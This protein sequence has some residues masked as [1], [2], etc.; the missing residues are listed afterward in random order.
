MT[1]GKRIMIWLVSMLILLAAAFSVVN[2][3]NSF[4]AAIASSVAQS[5]ADRLD[6][7]TTRPIGY[8]DANTP[9]G[10]TLTFEKPVATDGDDVLDVDMEIVKIAMK[11]GELFVWFEHAGRPF[12]VSGEGYPVFY[13]NTEFAMSPKARQEPATQP[14]ESSLP[15]TSVF[16]SPHGGCQA[17]IVAELAKA[18]A[19]VQ[20]E[21]YL[22]TNHV[23]M[24]AL[25]AAR[26]RKVNVTVILDGREMLVNGFAVAELTKG[27]VAV[28]TNSRH[29][30][31][32][33]KIAVVDGKVVVG[34][35]FNWTMQA[36]T[37]NAENVTVTRNVKVAQQYQANF[38]KLLAESV[39]WKPTTQPATQ[40]ATR[41][42]RQLPTFM[43]AS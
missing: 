18:K 4:N 24:D 37:S 12:P 2:H 5:E 16:F 11:A 3:A 39:R 43:V 6:I 7:R 33:N 31:F 23:L 38:V 40:P 1:K 42:A 14:A 15:E 26:V 9:I 25:I 10:T 32:H 13:W 28:W 35:S 19:S 30:V 27:G 17:A 41:S 29:N 34:G 21:M 8:I 36:E 22:L 20:V